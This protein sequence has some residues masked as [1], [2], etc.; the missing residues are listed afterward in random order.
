MRQWQCHFTSFAGNYFLYYSCTRKTCPRK[1]NCKVFIFSHLI[2][3]CILSQKEEEDGRV[4]VEHAE[5]GNDKIIEIDEKKFMK[6]VKLFRAIPSC[7]VYQNG[8][9]EQLTSSGLIW[10]QT[11]FQLKSSKASWFVARF[12]QQFLRSNFNKTK[13]FK[14]KANKKSKR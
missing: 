8:S 11:Y 4:E 9:H 2:L 7:Y 3:K 12:F 5:N 14:E 13:N 6:K 10:W 1:T